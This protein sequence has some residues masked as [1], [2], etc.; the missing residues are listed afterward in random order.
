MYFGKSSC[1]TPPGG[2]GVG[3]DY[4][5]ISKITGNLKDISPMAGQLS[6]DPEDERG[7]VSGSTDFSG[8]E[9]GKGMGN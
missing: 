1:R 3:S 7:S 5:D 8:L 6:R 2:G 4:K 9:M